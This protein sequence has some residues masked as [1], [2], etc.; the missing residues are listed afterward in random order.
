MVLGEP[1][2]VRAEAAEAIGQVAGRGLVL[3]TGVSTPIHA[4]RGNLMA[5]RVSVEECA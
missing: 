2:T 3:G 1:E 4:P 5:A